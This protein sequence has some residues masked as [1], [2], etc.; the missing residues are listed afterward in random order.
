ML[1]ERRERA[2]R[3]E[4]SVQHHLAALL[5]R[6]KR[7]DIQTADME[8]G[9]GGQRDVVLLEIDR[10]HRIG[11]VP[12]DIAM[13]QHRAFRAPGRAGRVHDHGDIVGSGAE[14]SR[15]VAARRLIEALPI[16]GI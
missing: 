5:Q 12:P 1:A 11:V 14:L 15:H 10:V 6:D 7:A 4:R 13:R 8:H 2:A 3:I 16:L 9:S